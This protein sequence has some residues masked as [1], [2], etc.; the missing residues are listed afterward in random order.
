L[1]LLVALLVQGTWALAGTT[2]SLT[3]TVVDTANKPVKGAKVSAVSPSQIS[4]TTTDANG[5]FSFLA[6]APDTYNVS[7]EAPGF[8]AATQAGI[9]VFADQ[10]RSLPITLGKLKEIVRVQ[11]RSATSLVRPGTTADVYAVDAT[12]QA[13]FQ[14]VGGGASLNTAY[15]A[16][17]TVPGVYVPQGVQGGN[18][19]GSNVYIRGGDYDQVGFEIDGVP[20]NRSFDNYPSG[21]AASIG[22]SQLEVYTGAAPANAEGQGLAGFINQV[23]RVGTYPGFV[24][25][26]FG[27]GGPAYYHKAAFEVGGATP[28]RN[29]TYYA[30]IDGYN[31]DFRYGDQFNG[32]N[33]N[34]LYGTALTPCPST[35]DAGGLVA[36]Y[37]CVAP[38]GQV[39]GYDAAGNQTVFAPTPS[40]AL[41]GY[42]LFSIANVAVRDAVFN[43]HVGLP[44]KNG[45]KDDIQFLAVNNSVSTS[46]YDSTGDQGSIAALNAIGL[47]QPTYYNGYQWNGP[48]FAA[49]PA[50]YRSMV[51]PYFYPQSQQNNFSTFSNPI[52]VDRR[53]AISNDQGIFK[54]QF[55][56]TFSSSALVKLYGYSYYSDW[57]QVDPQ[58]AYSNYFSGGSPDY[59]LSSHTRGASLT[60]SDQINSQN[61]LQ[62]QGSITTASSLRDNNTQMFNFSGSRG[63]LGAL[64]DSTNPTNGLCYTSAGVATTCS[65]SGP[66]SFFTLKQAYNGTIA[67]PTATTC[68]GG[69]CEQLVLNSSGYATYNTVKPRFIAGSLTDTFKPNSKLSIDLGIRLDHYEFQGSNTQDGPSRTFWYTA[70]NLDNCINNTNHQVVDKIVGGLTTSPTAPCP[71]GYSAANFTNPTGIVT[72][73]YNVYQPR[74]GFTYSLD[75]RTVVRGSYGRYAQAPNS[76]FEQYNYLQTNAPASLYGGAGGFALLG[77]T[78]PDHQVQPEV[79]NNYDFS[80]EHQFGNDLSIKISPFLRKTQNQIQQF[81][82]DQRTNFVSGTNVGNLTA[83]GFEFEVDKGNFGRN[84]LAG[85]LAFTYTNSYVRYNATPTGATVVDP[86]NQSIAQYNAYTSACAAGGKYAGTALCGQTVSKVAAAPCYSGGAPVAS[87]ALCTAGTVANPYWNAPAQGLLPVNGNFPTY[88]LIPGAIG[89]TATGY[90][91]PYVATLILQYKKDKFAFTPNLQFAAGQRYGAPLSTFGVAPDTC[92]GTVGATAGDPRYPYGAPGGS[93]FDAST[94]ALLAGGIPD[95]YTG[96]FDG[97]GGF[98]APSTLQLGAQFSYEATKNVT[99]VATLANVVNTCFGGTKTAFT[100][101]GACNYGVIAGGAGGDVGNAYNPGAAI[102]PLQNS[103]YQPSFTGYPFSAYFTAKV[104]I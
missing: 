57:L 1:A 90:G 24:T 27:I 2:G 55:T 61:L 84:G 26:D 88:D 36:G 74:I 30:G 58:S 64:V 73:V 44:H 40:F 56:H 92:G 42:N 3:G 17:A 69:P 62:F 100:V 63:I 4:N 39:Y 18:G 37:G 49:L 51:S 78:S 8:D 38:G 14:G 41:G 71:T 12:Q 48:I 76:A 10:S 13:A 22:Q 81:Y 53:D 102:Q 46:Y 93:S 67:T 77:F 101:P 33:F 104:K 83:Q 85:K 11:S 23:I 15:S 50:N 103:P 95:P 80:I 66:A 79:S 98:A 35:A 43:V 7:V 97:I 29:L 31:Q 6:L 82:L 75:P 32:Q 89:S 5:Q 65:Y 28:D 87:A 16:I 34:G 21:P 70:F 52:A 19:I 45:L 25:G 94:C 86:I 59:E 96:K 99:F 60:F 91:A 54:L 9:T 20:V 72:E 68:G 47:G